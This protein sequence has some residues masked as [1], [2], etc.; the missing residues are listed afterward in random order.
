LIF[1]QKLTIILFFT[2]STRRNANGMS[3]NSVDLARQL[4][5]K[6][7]EILR[8]AQQLEQQAKQESEKTGKNVT[9]NQFSPGYSEGDTTT[10]S[11]R[12]R[13]AF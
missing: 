5:Q 10:N 9:A 8:I 6:A 7:R 4:R 1:L 11:I 13:S 2:V 12:S 3:D